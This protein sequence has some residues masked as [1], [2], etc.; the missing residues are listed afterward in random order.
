MHFVFNGHVR[1][2]HTPDNLWMG[3]SQTHSRFQPIRV[4][5]DSSKRSAL[6][7]VTDKTRR[8]NCTPRGMDNAPEAGPVVDVGERLRGRYRVGER[9]RGHVVRFSTPAAASF[10]TMRESSCRFMR[11]CAVR[12]P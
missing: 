3:I 10:T 7:D 11:G 1:H 12:V 6:S 2:R 9:L 8:S 5:S 4:V